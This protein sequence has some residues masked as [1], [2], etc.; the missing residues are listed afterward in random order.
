[1]SN[2]LTN[3]TPADAVP[4]PSAQA[5]G[6]LPSTANSGRPRSGGAPFEPYSAT[7]TGC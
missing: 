2:S 5:D 3:P 1:M 6:G 7:G 4:E